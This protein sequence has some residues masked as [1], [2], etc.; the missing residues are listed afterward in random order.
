MNQDFGMIERLHALSPTALMMI[1]ISLI[2]RAMK[3]SRLARQEDWVFAVVAMTIGG[4]VYPQIAEISKVSY[5]VKFPEMVLTMFGIAMGGLTVTL[6]DTIWRFIVK[7]LELPNGS[8][9]FITKSRITNPDGGTTTK[10]TT[11]TVTE[12]K[13]KE[14][15]KEKEE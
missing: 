6:Q 1:C 10:V 12:P 5:D 15:E 9:E 11:T 13:E 8:T 2:L 14:K 3:L 4:I 7:R